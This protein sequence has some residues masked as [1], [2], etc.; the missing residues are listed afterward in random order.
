MHDIWN[1]WHGCTKK[2]E[3]CNHCYMYYLD[4]KR[5]K[6]GSIIFKTKNG[7]DYPLHKD[8]QGKYKIKAGELIRV[9]MTSDFFLEEAD[10]WRNDVWKI[11]NIRSDVKFYILTKRPERILDHLPINWNDGYDNVILNVSCE[12]QIRADERIPILLEIPAKH[13]GIMIAPIIGPINITSYL[14]TNQIEQVT[15][16]GEN[17]DGLRICHFDW[18]KNLSVE[19]RNANVSFDFIETGTRFMK[20][21]KI[22]YLP[23]KKL[24]SQMAYK[25]NVRFKGKEISFILKNEEGII[26]PQNELYVPKYYDNCL[27]CGSRPICNGCCK[28][29]KCK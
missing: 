7:F 10:E 6:D 21:D 5:D 3:G 22:Y 26:I 9:C 15:S 20:D 4:K 2:S 12:N 16:G 18:I 11:I 27:E 28:C 13:K 8:K 1:P 19:C 23:S 25:S 24:Q 17:Y 14:E 29:G